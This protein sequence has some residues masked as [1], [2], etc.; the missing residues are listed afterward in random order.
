[1]KLKIKK[2]LTLDAN[3]FHSLRSYETMTTDVFTYLYF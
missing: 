2:K 3:S 1:M